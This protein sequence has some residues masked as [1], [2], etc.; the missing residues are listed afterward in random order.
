MQSTVA[1]FPQEV[2]RSLKHKL[3]DERNVWITRRRRD[4][5]EAVHKEKRRRETISSQEVT[6]NRTTETATKEQVLSRLSISR[7]KNTIRRNRE[8]PPPH[9][10]SSMEPIPSSNPSNESVLWNMVLK[11]DRLMPHNWTTLRVKRLPSQSRGEG[12]RWRSVIHLP[13]VHIINLRGN[14]IIATRQG[15]FDQGDDG[16]TT[17]RTHN[18]PPST[19]DCV[20]NHRLFWETYHLRTQRSHKV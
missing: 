13:K 1:L 6:P 18:P 15:V 7:P 14:A 4:P 11:P 10:I 17:A 9:A 19:R 2:D 5:S 8:A 16:I 3:D 12:E 20:S